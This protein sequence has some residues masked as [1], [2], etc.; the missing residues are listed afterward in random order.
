MKDSRASPC[1]WSSSWARAVG[2]WG[3]LLLNKSKADS[4]AGGALSHIL[5]DERFYRTGSVCPVDI[6]K[7]IFQSSYVLVSSSRSLYLLLRH[8]GRERKKK[9]VPLWGRECILMGCV[10][11]TWES[12]APCLNSTRVDYGNFCGQ[13]V[14]TP[15]SSHTPTQICPWILLIRICE[16][17]ISGIG[18]WSS[19]L[20]SCPYIITKPVPMSCDL[21]VP[22]TGVWLIFRNP[23]IFPLEFCFHDHLKQKFYQL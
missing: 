22:E 13:S 11:A 20:E 19:A 16:M 5:T 1:Q 23:N 12:G 6:G 10:P 15:A 2:P 7:Y 4:K 17:K 18:T 14:C 3:I 9:K 21:R 8:N